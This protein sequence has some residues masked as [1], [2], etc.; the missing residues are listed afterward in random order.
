MSCGGYIA[1]TG[2]M[3]GREGFRSFNSHSSFITTTS[4]PTHDF[5]CSFS[6]SVAKSLSKAFFMLMVVDID[7]GT[8]RFPFGDFGGLGI[9]GSDFF[10]YRKLGF[11]V[12]NELLKRFPNPPKAPFPKFY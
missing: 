2:Q 12:A 4:L 9:L 8:N 3:E 11:S 5:F 7:G 10:S 6:L 1:V